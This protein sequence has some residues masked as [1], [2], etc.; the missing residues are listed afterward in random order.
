MENYAIIASLKSETMGKPIDRIPDSRLLIS[1]LPSSA[2]RMH[3]EWLASLTMSTSVLK[4][5]PGKLNIKR[6]SLSILYFS[7]AYP[8]TG[9][10]ETYEHFLTGT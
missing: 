6:H 3:V 8:S 7:S 5:L 4:A 10:Q 1:S 9:Y 2:L